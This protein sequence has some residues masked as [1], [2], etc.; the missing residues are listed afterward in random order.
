[1]RKKGVR[2]VSNLMERGLDS[3][4]LKEFHTGYRHA[5]SVANTERIVRYRDVPGLRVADR[6]ALWP[7]QHPAVVAQ[8]EEL[9][10]A[11]LMPWIEGACWYNY[12]QGRNPLLRDESISLA[13]ALVKAYVALEERGLAHC[14]PSPSN[15][16]FSPAFDRVE[17]VD[18]EDMYGP[19]F[20]QPYPVPAG[21]SGYSPSWMKTR[22]SWSREGDRFGVALL[23]SEILGWAFEDVRALCSS[24]SFFEDD[25]LGTDSRRFRVLHQR[26]SDVSPELS[27]LFEMVWYSG[28]SQACPPIAD[29]QASLQ[30]IPAVMPEFVFEPLG[31]LE[32]RVDSDVTEDITIN[33]PVTSAESGYRAVEDSAE[34]RDFEIPEGAGSTCTQCGR[35]VQEG[36]RTCPFC[37]A[38]VSGRPPAPILAETD[39]ESSELPMVSRNQLLLRFVG[40]FAILGVG[41][42]LAV[43][44]F[45]QTLQEVQHGLWMISGFFWTQVIGGSVIA[46]LAGGV[47]AWVFRHIMPKEK[48]AWFVAAALAGGAIGGVA[49]GMLLNQGYIRDAALVGAVTGILAGVVSGWGQS[50]LLRSGAGKTKWLWYSVVSYAL[51]WAVGW[52]LSWGIG[53][54]PGTAAAAAFIMVA[55][56]IALALFLK[57]SPEVEF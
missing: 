38:P 57:N 21:T 45:Q 9:A 32:L 29:W 7:E 3:F 44:L 56:G 49:S 30:E 34:S 10:Y 47:Q 13:Q 40:I 52:L 41:L 31:Q 46:L 5:T 2:A 18:I 25:E 42:A 43:L 8:R 48:V 12:V 54:E 11:V 6:L 23:T 55:S 4:A 27:R 51:I 37:S 20:P 53:D 36:W 15:F 14:D 22:G 1:M 16:I 17:L 33:P 19:D 35:P 26:L 50:P 28:S 39:W 24:G